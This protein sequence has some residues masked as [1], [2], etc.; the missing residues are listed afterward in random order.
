MFSTEIIS[1]ILGILALWGCFK[2]YAEYLWFRIITATFGIGLT[3]LIPL[4]SLFISY[5][6]FFEEGA[7]W[8]AI[9]QIILGWSFGAIAF[10]YSIGT[11]LKFMKD[12]FGKSEVE[13]IKNKSTPKMANLGKKAEDKMKNEA[14]KK[15]HNDD[16]DDYGK[17]LNEQRAKY[18]KNK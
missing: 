6:S 17:F 16:D 18:N 7:L 8:L 9:I 11:Y 15:F 2:L 4:G 13:T 12:T 3:L 5:I 10:W 14:W 1:I